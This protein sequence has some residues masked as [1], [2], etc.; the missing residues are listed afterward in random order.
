ML[1]K[2]PNL[3]FGLG[4]RPE[5]YPE[6]HD[7]DIRVDWFEALSENFM[8]AGGP[9][10][11]HLDR[12]AERFPVVLHGV[13]LNIGGPDGLDA[14]YL[15]DLRA[16][17][18]RVKAPWVSDH[19]CWTGGQGLNLHD[20]LPL[21]LIREAVGLIADRVKAVQDKLGRPFALENP[22]TYITY[23]D[24]EMPEW[25]FLGA[26]AEAADC[27]ILL[28]VNNVYVSSRNHGFDAGVYLSGLPVERVCQIHL[29][30][31]EDAGDILI[32]THDH[33]VIDPVFDLYGQALRLC[34]P[35]TTMIERDD[36]IPPL[37][38]VIAELDRAR[39]IAAAVLDRA[40]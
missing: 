23:Q 37:A 16:L 15:G 30:G 26:I 24:D 35:V 38:D 18:D 12:I 6:I 4:L 21:P 2:L 3:G 27:R 5:H 32:D 29:A 40:A 22:S 10:L 36:K 34:G 14:A 13:S 33:P 28:D 11:D 25:D 1:T 19:L 8:V 20:L 39:A 7:R 9:P 31:H 17:A